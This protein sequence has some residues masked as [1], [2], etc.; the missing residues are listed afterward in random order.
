LSLLE[1]RPINSYSTKSG[2][3][4]PLCQGGLEEENYGENYGKLPGLVK[5]PKTRKK[6]QLTAATWDRR[7]YERAK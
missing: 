1:K 7:E 6:S 3:K 4:M 2:W 5:Q